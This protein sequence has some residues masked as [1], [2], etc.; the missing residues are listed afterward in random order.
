MSDPKLTLITLTHPRSPAAEAY[1]ALRANLSLT[2]LEHPLRALVVTS[3]APGEDKSAALAN[4][5][6]VMAQGGQRVI[7]V[8]ADLRHPSLHELFGV[9]NERGLATV[10]NEQDALT[11][12]PLSPVPDVENLELLTS[13]PTPLD[14]AAQ[15]GSKR[16]EEAVA[17]LQ[18][19][20]DVVLFAAPPVLVATDAVVLGMKTDGVLLVVRAGHT[21]RDHVQQAKEKLEKARVRIAGV[22]LTNTHTDKSL[23]Y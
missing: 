8:D 5:A 22:A 17:A 12:P 11:A 16:M 20:A 10:L 9:Q 15:L 3:A 1:R 4:L 23:G 19:R 14:P 13:G 18:K 2:S 6:I 21:S 7:L